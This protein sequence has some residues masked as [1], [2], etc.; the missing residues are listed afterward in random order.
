MFKKGK[1]FLVCTLVA[2]LV[3]NGTAYAYVE[4]NTTTL[5]IRKES[6]VTNQS[7]SSINATVKPYIFNK[8]EHS[9]SKFKQES[10]SETLISETPD[11]LGNR[12]G[13]FLL[14]SIPI[15]EEKKVDIETIVE[16]SEVDFELD[17]ES[18][19]SNPT[20]D[21]KLDIY[22]QPSYFVESDNLSI[23]AKANEIKNKIPEDN[24]NNP[25][26]QIQAVYAFVQTNLHYTLEDGYCSIGAKKALEYLAGDCTEYSTLMVAL[27]RAIGVP[28]RTI[29][30][31]SLSTDKLSET[32]E[33]YIT[34]EDGYYTKHTWV[35][36]WINGYGWVP[37]DPTISGEESTYNVGEDTI[38]AHE[39]LATPDYAYF[40]RLT[41]VYVAEQIDGFEITDTVSVTNNPTTFDNNY[42]AKIILKSLDSIEIV[43][44]LNYSETPITLTA[45]GVSG[46]IRES[47]PNID[48]TWSS[49]DDQIATVNNGVVTFT[50]KNGEVSITAEYKGVKD[51]V[52]TTVENVGL[53][54]ISIGAITYSDK[55]IDLE[56]TCHYSDGSTKKISEGVTWTSS[57][58]SVAD[59]TAEN[60]LLFTNIEGSIELE[61]NYNGLSD[62]IT[63]NAQIQE[64]RVSRTVINFNGLNNMELKITK[65]INGVGVDIT[66]KVNMV[67]NNTNVVMI[68]EN[69]NLLFKNDGTAIITI[70]YSGYTRIVNVVVCKKTEE[71][72]EEIIQELDESVSDIQDE[73]DELEEIEE[74]DR[75]VKIKKYELKEI[76]HKIEIMKNIEVKDKKLKELKIIKEKIDRIEDEINELK[77]NRYIKYIEIEGDFEY[78]EDDVDL[79]LKVYYLDGSRK[80]INRGAD[81]RS[82]N[83]ERATV[84]K[85]GRVSF[86][87]EEGWVT[88]VA[89]YGGKRDKIKTKV[90]FEEEES[91]GK[92]YSAK[93]W[94]RICEPI[95]YPKRFLQPGEKIIVAE[96][97]ESEESKK[98]YTNIKDV[99]IKNIEIIG[100]LDPGLMYNAFNIDINYKDGSKKTVGINEVKWTSS[101][102]KVATITKDGVI[103]FTGKAG[104]LKITAQYKGHKQTIEDDIHSFDYYFKQ[105]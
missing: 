21:S 52:S 30:G 60:K 66:D 91:K 28:A 85:Y 58:T 25:Y 44:N 93:E 13:E 49:S 81:W 12:I 94:Q 56:I 105:D 15:N 86:T 70:T 88:I 51:T 77:D 90:E 84:D 36:V 104:H 69:N 4:S 54:S 53:E 23:I 67:S 31:Y 3:A 37:C 89:K 42:Y 2:L 34:D 92:R 47:I 8:E 61:A 78:S 96:T 59:I 55:P 98:G 7:D 35:E 16:V 26:Y 22:L 82:E 48:I 18:I 14:S 29:C 10:Y 6:K 62:K 73:I 76:I 38:V 65:V 101:N 46:E 68:D 57:N 83:K 79:D 97:T 32:V 45:E 43:E 71:E 11:S 50:G 102:K 39:P 74:L 64:I 87:G 27:L 40:G 24:R 103:V 20:Y 72:I 99:N 63:I 95:N 19:N 41:H 33:G 100:K 80:T 9:Y 17:P 5:K 1:C 75:K